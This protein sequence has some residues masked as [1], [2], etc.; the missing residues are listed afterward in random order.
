[1]I[2]I[3]AGL[4]AAAGTVYAAA[5]VFLPRYLSKSIPTPEKRSDSEDRN[6]AIISATFAAIGAVAAFLYNVYDDSE[7]EKLRIENEARKT[8][9]DY[10]AR[11]NGYTRDI[12]HAN[13]AEVVS[14]LY[15]VGLMAAEDEDIHRI[16]TEVMRTYLHAQVPLPTDV[17]FHSV[18]P[19]AG[20][21]MGPQTAINVLGWRHLAYDPPHHTPDLSHLMLKGAT[22]RGMNGYAKA[23]FYGSML[24]ATDFRYGDF[25][26]TRFDGA[27]FDDWVAY[28]TSGTGGPWN[29]GIPQRPGWTWERYSYAANFFSANLERAQFSGARLSGA[30]FTNARL[31]GARFDGATLT[32]ADFTGAI[33]I[34]KAVF[35]G[36][37][38]DDMAHFPAALKSNP[39]IR[40]GC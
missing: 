38:S 24:P 12:F 14:M 37:C 30:I 21:T 33:D 28:Q 5:Y 4:G 25:S 6:R 1:M 27:V 32:R 17:D 22:F 31:A 23:L 7:K 10:I 36:A 16:M 40:N 26:G 20:I 9:S 2:E 34:D 29:S 35:D 15:S 11:L 3:L 8:R 18:T 19:V 39:A 13:P